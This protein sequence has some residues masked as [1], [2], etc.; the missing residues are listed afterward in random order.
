MAYPKWKYHKHEEP[1][2]VHSEEHEKELGDEWKESP[3]DHVKP[4][5][6]KQEPKPEPKKKAKE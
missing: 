1:K 4:E 5:M 3:A 6:P 2:L